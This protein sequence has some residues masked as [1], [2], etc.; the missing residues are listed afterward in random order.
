MRKK[1][2]DQWYVS[3]VDKIA[4]E[5]YLKDAWAEGGMVWT[6]NFSEAL[7]FSNIAVAEQVSHAGYRIR[8]FKPE[9]LS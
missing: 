5:L 2:Q 4:G 8:K 7:R 6:D 3:V 1:P 9:E